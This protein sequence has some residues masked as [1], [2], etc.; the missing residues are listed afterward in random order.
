MTTKIKTLLT[1][2]HPVCGV[3]DGK[4]ANDPAIRQAWL[5]QRAGGFTATEARDWTN[6]SKRRKIIEAKVTGNTED[7]SHIP[8]VAHGNLREP[9]IAEWVQGKFDIEPCDNV[10][11]RAGEP[12]HLASPDGISR[13]PF[14]R[15]IIVGRSDAILCEIK[16]SKHDLNPGTVDTDGILDVIEPESHFDRSGYYTQMQWQMYV[17]NAVRTLFVWEQHDGTID[18]ETGT[19]RPIGPPRWVWVPRDDVLIDKLVNDVAPRAL[20]EIDAARA[21]AAGGMPPASDADPEVAALTAELLK[22]RDAEAVAKKV[23]EQAW[24]KLQAIYLATPEGA[25]HPENLSADIGFAR[26]T[27][28]T[29]TKSVLKTDMAAAT[30]RAPKLV[31]QYEALVKRYTRPTEETKTTFTITAKEDKS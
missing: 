20:A 3:A 1:G 7:L 17:M 31:A 13:D 4:G 2:D 27:V 16:T 14:T 25:D 9:I 21:A 10:Y 26:I 29:T 19:F 15:E 18:P 28:N 11:S 24:A 30:K 23:K 5:N 12:R 6:P 8:A 22:A